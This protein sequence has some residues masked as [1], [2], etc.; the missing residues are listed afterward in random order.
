MAKNKVSEWSSS[1]I[2]NTDI[3]GIDIAEGC[4]PS[5]INNA[6][7]EMMAQVKDMQ[8]G[9]DADNFTIGGNLSVSGTAT[10]M[11]D[12]VASAGITADITGNVIGNVI[13][14]V[15]GN[16]TGNVT[17]NVS[18]TSANIT[19]TVAV[20]N[21]GTGAVSL[22]ANSILIGNG[23]GAIQELAPSASGS[24]LQSNGTSWESAT[25][26]RLTSGTSQSVGTGTSVSFTS[27]PSWA[28]RITVMM[29]A[30]SSNG[31]SPFIIQI[32]TGG[33]AKTSGYE[34]VGI[35]IQGD[36]NRLQITNGFGLQQSV[37]TDTK[38]Y[39]HAVLTKQTGNTW[40]FS[41]NGVD[42]VNNV[43]YM[44]SGVGTLTGT[45][46][47]IFLTTVIG[48]TNFDAGTINIMYE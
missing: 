39:G 36:P 3:G 35:V 19:G 42:Y 12:F 20:A 38:M 29:N 26:N 41:F 24:V 21:G 17:G 46:D 45:L 23:T 8:S 10:I 30:V 15:T 14:N 28:T 18:G 40:I 25:L 2:N 31:S 22:T 6:I 43:G 5:G 7:R 48:S 27:I 34:S 13:G 16:L 47:S 1:A 4:A 44:G 37:Q 11:G 33:V 32:G 9:S